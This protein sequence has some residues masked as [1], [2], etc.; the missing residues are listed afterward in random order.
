MIVFARKLAL[1]VSP[2]SASD[3]RCHNGETNGIRPQYPIFITSRRLTMALSHP[4]PPASGS[5][6]LS[7]DWACQDKDQ[8]GLTGRG[9]VDLSRHYLKSLQ[10]RLATESSDCPVS[11]TSRYSLSARGR[12]QAAEHGRDASAPPSLVV[13]RGLP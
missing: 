4:V 5:A 9:C 13:S 3:A 7:V 10:K 6:G 8:S 11:T 12:R 1:V 2:S